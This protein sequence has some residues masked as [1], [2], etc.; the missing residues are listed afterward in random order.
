MVSVWLAF[1]LMG[2]QERGNRPNADTTQADSI[3]PVKEQ[4]QALQVLEADQPPLTLKGHTGDVKSVAFSADGKRLA[5]VNEDWTVKVWDA[6]SGQE[7]LTL[8]GHTHIV[9]SVSFSPNGKR[10][11]SA[12][13]DG[14][15]KLWDATPRQSL[16]IE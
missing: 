10:L 1:P 4:A 12:S 2:G 16:V 3:A 8:K 14:T 5:S 11:A 7:T 9:T 15:V 13:W 6:T